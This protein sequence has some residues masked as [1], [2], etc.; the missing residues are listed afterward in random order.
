MRVELWPL[1]GPSPHQM[2]FEWV[3]NIV[4]VINHMAQENSE[5]KTCVIFTFHKSQVQCPEIE[6]GPVQ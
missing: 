1:M 6:P 2:M 3:G 5:V 4:G